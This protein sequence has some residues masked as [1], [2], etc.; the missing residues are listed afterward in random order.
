MADR[1]G[2]PS[3]AA[4]TPGADRPQPCDDAGHPASPGS[5]RRRTARRRKV[6]VGWPFWSGQA[7]AQCEYHVEPGPGKAG[8]G[9][10]ATATSGWSIM[11]PPTPGRS[12]ARRLRAGGRG[13]V[14]LSR[15]SRRG[16]RRRTRWRGRPAAYQRTTSQGCPWPPTG[17]GP[18]AILAARSRRWSP[19]S[20]RSGA[21]AAAEPNARARLALKRDPVVAGGR[22]GSIGDVNRKVAG[23]RAGHR[24]RSPPTRR[25]A[26]PP[27]RRPR[28]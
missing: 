11:L 14:R 19:G 16:H 24:P 17:H 5:R 26:D 6:Q 10:K 28:R 8:R 20:R 2:W 23:R 9:G 18:M 22:R 4:P 21:P 12:A 27:T 13:P 3:A 7:R 15:A 1:A 25:P